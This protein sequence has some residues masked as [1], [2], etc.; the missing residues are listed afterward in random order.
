MST[1]TKTPTAPRRRLA[2]QDKTDM[3]QFVQ[4]L[5]RSL[6]IA[7]SDVG[8]AKQTHTS[9]TRPLAIDP[10][11]RIPTPSPRPFFKIVSAP[12]PNQMNTE[13][14]SA[15]MVS[16]SRPKPSFASA[17]CPQEGPVSAQDHGGSRNPLHQE[18]AMGLAEVL[19]LLDTKERHIKRLKDQLSEAVV[20]IS[21][22]KEKVQTLLNQGQS[23]TS[24]AVA[25]QS[26]PNAPIMMA[27]NHTSVVNE[28]MSSKRKKKGKKSKTNVLLPAIAAKTNADK[29]KRKEIGHA[30]V[31]PIGT[32]PQSRIMNSPLGLAPVRL[33][34]NWLLG[35]Q[36]SS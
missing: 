36:W 1:F 6:S 11:V 19:R 14:D 4:L 34:C 27:H 30:T 22:I 8:A 2:T 17:S 18:Q 10:I 24:A 32:E 29:G 9:P 31:V 5:K 21:S 15:T 28:A 13:T 20:D 12:T 7:D 3:P 35:G 25:N 23:I 33:S 16:K 26:S